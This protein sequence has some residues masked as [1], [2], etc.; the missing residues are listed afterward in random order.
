M[1]NIMKMLYIYVQLQ[2]ICQPV[3]IVNISILLMLQCL[4]MQMWALCNVHACAD[5]LLFFNY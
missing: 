1:K 3:L 2:I 5:I 4:A